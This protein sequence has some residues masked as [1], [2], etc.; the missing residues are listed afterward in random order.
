V[1]NELGIKFDTAGGLQKLTAGTGIK[2]NATSPGLALSSSGLNALLK[3]DAGL[4][5]DANGLYVVSNTNA[6]IMVN[7]FGVGIDLADSNPGLQFDVNGDLQLKAY[8]SQGLHVDSDGVGVTLEAAGSNTGGLAFNGTSG[9]RV[10]TD[11]LHGVMLTSD[12]VVAKYDSTKGITLF[13]GALG[14]YL[15]PAGTGVGGLQFNSGTNKLEVKADT[16]RAISLTGN[17]VGINYD[18]V[19][20]GVNGSNQLYV[21]SALSNP[22]TYAE[23]LAIGDPVYFTG[24]AST[25]G[26][27]LANADSKSWI[28]GLALEAASSG[29][30]LVACD[31]SLV[32]TLSGLTIGVPYYL[33][34]AGGLTSTRPVA[35]GNRVIMV[36]VA[37]ATT[38]LLVNIKDFGKVA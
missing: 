11:G 13:S 3:T 2:L 25:V 34:A 15:E 7:S 24:S 8:T 20:L 23:S 37:Y 17:G 16:A 12:G 6:G 36:G 18:T 21:K 32:T 19:S 29:T 31:G 38:S 1:A 33:A 14:V 30:H 27:A 4:G 5:K 9:I 26:K 35:S 28:V 10:L 22:F